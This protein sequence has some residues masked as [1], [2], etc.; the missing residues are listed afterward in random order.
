MAYKRK[1]TLTGAATQGVNLGNAKFAIQPDVAVYVV[2]G[3][4]G[5]VADAANGILISGG[6]FF[7]DRTQGA[8]TY[9]HVVPVAGSMNAKIFVDE[10]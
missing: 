8:N 7:E 4:S 2:I 9:V 10:A 6:G 1:T 3:G 5:D